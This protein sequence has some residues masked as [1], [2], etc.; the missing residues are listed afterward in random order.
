MHRSSLGPAILV[1]AV[2]CACGRR[3]VAETGDDAGL[4]GEG[5][6]AS[7]GEGEGA[8]EGEGEGP[9][10]GEG[11]GASEGEG[12]GASEGEGEGASEGEGEGEGGF[13]PG[14]LVSGQEVAL[15]VPAVPLGRF[16]LDWGE[17]VAAHCPIRGERLD[18]VAVRAFP[19]DLR[20]AQRYVDLARFPSGQVTGVALREMTYTV[21]AHTVDRSFGRLE[22]WIG[23]PGDGPEDE[24][25]LQGAAELGRTDPLVAGQASGRTAPLRPDWADVAGLQ[26]I[27]P[28]YAFRAI[29]RLPLRL[30]PGDCWGLEGRIQVSVALGLTYF[31]LVP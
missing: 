19:V 26:Q 9:S 10:E 21:H 22:V 13:D 3:D 20:A 16:E 7:E 5:E 28:A 14:P 1:L 29:T 17:V 31:W 12:E 15:L 11:E 24:T 25:A 18:V 27:L 23:P 2:V 6:G 4:E 8:A 30:V